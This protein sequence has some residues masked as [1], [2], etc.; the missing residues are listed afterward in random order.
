MTKFRLV[1]PAGAP[2]PPHAVLSATFRLGDDGRDLTGLL[3]DQLKVRHVFAVSSGRAA[4]TIILQA[5]KRVSGRREVVIPAYTCFS[6]PSA[7]ARAGL[8]IRLCDVD[9]KTLDLDQSALL[10]LDLDRVL[11]IIPSSLYGIPADLVTLERLSRASG[12]FLVDDAAQCL[13]ATADK[14]PCGTFGDAGFYSFGRGKN[15]S[16]MGGGILLTSREDLAHLIQNEVN[17]LPR[18]SSVNV[19]SSIV[20]S[21]LYA[22][23]LHPSRYW[24]PNGIP[25]LELGESRF[26]PNFKIARL[27]AYQTRLAAQL[28]P[29]VDSYN[30]IRRDNADRLQAGIEGLEGIEI[31]R[32]GQGANPV[33]LRFPILARDGTHRARLLGRLRG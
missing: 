10:R 21:L 25:F 31:P 15:I 7:V 1:P 5:L 6:V 32:A 17:K 2:V 18:P 27:S 26:D 4:L 13:G 24:I 22:V 11:C 23:M 29:F 3:R 30:G 19:L 20:N 16:T 14:R 12:A 33:Y 9:P 8:T 28:F